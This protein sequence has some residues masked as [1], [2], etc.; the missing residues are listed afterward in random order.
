[1]VCEV[2]EG[3]KDSVFR[4]YLELKIFKVCSSGA[5]KSAEIV[6]VSSIK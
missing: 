1:V 4:S 5:E 3:S 2:P 6:N